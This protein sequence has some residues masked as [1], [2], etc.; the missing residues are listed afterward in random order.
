MALMAVDI[1]GHIPQ[2]S[3]GHIPVA[4]A[5]ACGNNPEMN[6][7]ILER[8][9]ARLAYVKEAYRKS[10]ADV[11][12]EAGLGRD[13]IRDMRRREKILPR[14]DT[15]SALADPLHT[16][17]EWLAF[18]RGQED[19]SLVLAG[20][21][22]VPILSWVAASAFAD[23][24]LGINLPT[25]GPTVEA[26]NLPAG[27][28]IALR[29]EGDS[30]NKIA[31]HGSL[32]IVRINDKQLVDRGFYVFGSV[33]GTTFKRYRDNDGPARLEPYSTSEHATIFPEGP[34]EVIGRVFRVITDLYHLRIR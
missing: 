5:P 20:I 26:T 6:R 11:C 4:S 16:T 29:V 21:R 2:M 22:E 8:I 18:G 34:V 13:A 23:A 32:I 30:M 33:D 14:L 1:A 19:P 27:E 10:E 28:Y 31:V 7:T 15:L 25:D 12:R 3:T 17:P 9:E 24:T